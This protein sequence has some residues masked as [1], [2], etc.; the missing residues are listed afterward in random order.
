[1]QY[2]RP[3][4]FI[5]VNNACFTVSNASIRNV[6]YLFENNEGESGRGK[7]GG[8]GVNK[9]KNIISVIMNMSTLTL[10]HIKLITFML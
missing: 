8:W 2:L 9:Q 4:K 1:M 6:E 5:S 7:K 3:H 10:F